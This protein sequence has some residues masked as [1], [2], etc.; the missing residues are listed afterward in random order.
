MQRMRREG[1]EGFKSSRP[2]LK[3]HVPKADTLRLGTLK[4]VSES[5]C[6]NFEACIR[7]MSSPHRAMQRLS[8]GRARDHPVMEIVPN[9]ALSLS[10]SLSVCLVRPGKIRRSVEHR[11][12]NAYIGQK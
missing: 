11:G 5:W 4:H 7:V 1:V 8:A 6:Q 9:K 10:L 12:H 2:R 3:S